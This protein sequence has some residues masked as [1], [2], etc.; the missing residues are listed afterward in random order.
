MVEE[1]VGGVRRRGVA[2]RGGRRWSGW[3]KET[4]WGRQRREEMEYPSQQ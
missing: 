1:G 2:G 4:G 3:G